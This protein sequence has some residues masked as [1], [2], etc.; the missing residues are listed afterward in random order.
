[1][2][3]CVENNLCLLFTMFFLKVCM[4]LKLC[5]KHTPLYY[6][7][8][9]R[10]CFVND[11]IQIPI[12]RH[13]RQVLHSLLNYIRCLIIKLIIMKVNMTNISTFFLQRFS[14][15]Q[16]QVVKHAACCQTPPSSGHNLDIMTSLQPL[17]PFQKEY[18]GFTCARRS[19]QEHSL[20]VR[21]D[22]ARLR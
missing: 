12:L 14:N 8:F 21:V 17:L 5:L 4:C 15:L 6:L 16:Q 1:M 18:R 11:D 9:F 2:L 20:K 22:Q 10:S 19:G 7:L 3:Y 13:L